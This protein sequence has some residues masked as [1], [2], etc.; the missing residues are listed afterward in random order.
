[1]SHP[2]ETITFE[3]GFTGQLFDDADVERPYAHNDA[4]RI[5]IL[6]RRYEDPAR[7]RCGTTPEQLAEWTVANTDA[8]WVIPLFA[9]EHGGVVY[10][11]ANNNP[12]QCPFD[13]G[14]AGSIALRRDHFPANEAQLRLEAELIAST[15][16]AWANGECYRFTLTDANGKELDTG[17]GIIGYDAAIAALNEAAALCADQSAP[18]PPP[19]QE[20]EPEQGCL[21][22]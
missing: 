3:N 15:Y 14:R 8:W 20:R 5:V 6:S 7:G 21:F 22:G 1:M 18:S 13:S 16:S 11:P 4:V 17:W 9:Y 12:F 19:P 2:I 10:R